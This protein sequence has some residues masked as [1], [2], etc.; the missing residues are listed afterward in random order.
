MNPP[1]EVDSLHLNYYYGQGLLSHDKCTHMHKLYVVSGHYLT[2][3]GFGLYNTHLV[4]IECAASADV[5]NK[6][7]RSIISPHSQ[8][9]ARSADI[10]TYYQ[11]VVG[12]ERLRA[13]EIIFQPSMLGIDQ[14]GL[15]DTLEYVLQ[16]FP[17]DV[18][19]RL[20]QV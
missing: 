5:P 4:R 19:Q 14:S 13:P 12:V 8:S 1:V 17:P 6:C 16:Y 7:A 11:M 10:A 9:H 20:V 2:W 3:P 18:Q 15:S